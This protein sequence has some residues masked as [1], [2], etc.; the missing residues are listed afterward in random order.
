MNPR[1][2]ATSSLPFLNGSTSTETVTLLL[3]FIG[4]SDALASKY[5]GVTV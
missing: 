3:G 5:R 1:V 4:R 2:N